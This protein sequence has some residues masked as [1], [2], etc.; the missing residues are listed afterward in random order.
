MRHDELSNEKAQRQEGEAN[1]KTLSP[2]LHQ[3][4]EFHVIEPR[5]VG[6]IMVNRLFDEMLCVMA[7]GKLFQV[8]DKIHRFTQR[9]LMS[10][11]HNKILSVS[12]QIPFLKR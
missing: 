4:P 8:D 2:P 11:A 3:P 6:E 12:I 10:P 1:H 7:L 5:P 9:K